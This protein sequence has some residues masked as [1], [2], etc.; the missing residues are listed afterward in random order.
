MII[1]KTPEELERMRASGRIAARVRDELA[2]KIAPGV[3]TGELDEYARE[4]IAAAGA[5]S[6][7][8]G[9]RG[10]P[11]A[12]CASLNNVVVHGIP[13]RQR[14]AL[15]D[16]VSLDVGVVHEGFVGDTATTVLV[17]VTD[18]NVVR[19]VSVAE[20]AL[21]Q[22]IAEAVAGARLSDISHAIEQVVVQAGFSVVR[23]FVGHGVGRSMH[24]DPQIPNYGPPGR[25]PKLKVGMTLAIEPM[26]NM[27]V[28]DVEVLADGWTVTTKDRLPSAHV[29]HTVAVLE[30]RAEILTKSSGAV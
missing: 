8:L 11:G 22:G 26:V 6:A 17:G 12:I 21:E 9:Y 3:T 30:G 28:A 15:G 14:I 5:R 10:F 4:L 2:K 13:G 23:E 7:F 1:I 27:G 18:P 20:Q 16:V 24:E 19:L 25:G 29:E